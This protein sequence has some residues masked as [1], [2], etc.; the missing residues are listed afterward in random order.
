MRPRN[1]GE[2]GV[3]IAFGADC[4]WRFRGR[5][6]SAGVGFTAPGPV[7]FAATTSQECRQMT[8]VFSEG[9]SGT[10]PGFRV[11]RPVPGQE[12]LAFETLTSCLPR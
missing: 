7:P 9:S 2:F 1:Q 4:G 11:S 3:S 12:T 6:G 8:A 5:F 10:I